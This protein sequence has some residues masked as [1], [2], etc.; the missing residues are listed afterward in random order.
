MVKNKIFCEVK[1]FYQ[2]IP[3]IPFR[4]TKGVR[5]DIAPVDLIPRIDGIDRVLHDKGALSPSE[6][7]GVKRPWY[8]HTHQR[9]YLMVL[10]GRR[11][12]DIYNIEY[13]KM[14]S[15]EVA[16]DY[17]KRGDEFLYEGPAMLVWDF[18]VFHRIRSADE[19]SASL[20]FAYRS[21]GF[22]IKTNFNIYELDREKGIFKLLRQGFLDQEAVR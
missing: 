22:D 15:F 5:F 21:P 16:S 14:E 10:Q 12:T 8:M 7:A 2:I 18:N 13:K 9:D 6:V 4:R 1:N 20:N 17:I 3:L 19:G 11:F